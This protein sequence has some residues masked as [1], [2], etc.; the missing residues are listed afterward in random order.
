[1]RHERLACAV[2]LLHKVY[3]P[4]CQSVGELIILAKLGISE[5]LLQA[6]APLAHLAVLSPEAIT[7]RTRF[8]RHRLPFCMG[9]SKR[10]NV[11]R[12]GDVP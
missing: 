12:N 1:M 7:F 8:G 9:P 11:M 6:E 5:P 4:S 2:L 10:T 3:Q